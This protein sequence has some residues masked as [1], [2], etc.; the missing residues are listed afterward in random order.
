[1]SWGTVATTTSNFSSTPEK[2]IMLSS[3]YIENV[4]IAKQHYFFYF[5]FNF[6]E[7]MYLS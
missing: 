7:L 1:M 3:I 2:R 5:I 4:L 6:I